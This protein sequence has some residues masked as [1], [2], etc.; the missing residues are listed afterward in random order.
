MRK[1]NAKVARKVTEENEH[2]MCSCCGAGPLLE[3]FVVCDGEHYYC[4]DKCF[5]KGDKALW[6]DL[7]YGGDDV[8]EIVYWTEW[9]G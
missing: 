2:R 3:G 5:K 8:M 1:A 9:E 7:N 4:S 6:T